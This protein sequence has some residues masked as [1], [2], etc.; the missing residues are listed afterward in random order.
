MARI[1]RPRNRRSRRS[2]AALLDAAWRLIEERGAEAVT[3]E[4]VA[5]EAGV[6]RRAVYLHFP[7]RAEFFTALLNHI[8]E[9]LDLRGSIAP[10]VAAPDGPSA[11]D[12]W[13]THVAR[14]HA[15][16]RPVAQAVDRARR[17]DEGAAALWSRAMTNWHRACRALAGRL[18][19]EGL[20]SAP[21]TAET[22]ADLLWALMSVDLLEDLV[23]DRGWSLE[24]YA[25]LLAITVRRS[26]VGSDQGDH[27]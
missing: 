4:Q 21:W 7:S 5:Q 22:A 8:D 9:V 23:E 11:L 16:I 3:M 27:R 12:A 25:E 15:R 6:T 26:L 2:R 18:A 19:E 14:Y 10:I 24:R 20:L 13:A 1:E 17:T